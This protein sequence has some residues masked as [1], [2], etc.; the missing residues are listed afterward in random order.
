MSSNTIEIV[1]LRLRISTQWGIPYNSTFMTVTLCG[2][3]NSGLENSRTECRNAPFGHIQAVKTLKNVLN[4]QNARVSSFNKR[5]FTLGSAAVFQANPF[6]INFAKW[7]WQDHMN[8]CLML[9]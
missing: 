2:L 6:A 8:H 1:L 4:S 9:R 3:F 5:R 7:S